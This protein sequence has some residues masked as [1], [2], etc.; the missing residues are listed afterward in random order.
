M[1]KRIAFTT[2]FVVSEKSPIVYVSHDED[3]DWQ[4][5]G[6]ESD[7]KTEDG[8]I[9]SI[10]SILKIDHSIEEL[11]DMPRGGEARRKSKGS[12]WIRK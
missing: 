3:G 11:L 5:F 1:L 10:A 8:S 7:V 4:F 2:R 9:V 12:A 6:A